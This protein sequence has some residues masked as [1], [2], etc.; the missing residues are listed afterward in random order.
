[1]GAVEAFLAAIR[2]DPARAVVALDYDGTLAPIVERPEDAV[3]EPGAVDALVELAG[4][5]GTLAVITG[6]PA[7][8]VV[9]LG[10][11]DVVPGLVVLGQYGAQRWEAGE[12][13]SDPPSPG[14]AAVRAPLAALVADRA[15]VEDK[16]LSLVVHTRG[17]P[18]AAAVLESL[19]A[20]LTALAASHGLE[21]HPGRLVLEV[22]PPGHD[23]RRAL[24]SLCDPPPS[25]VLCAGDDLGDLPAFAALA[26][27]REAGVPG[28]VVVSAAD[29]APAEIRRSADLLVEGPPGV[30]RLLQ[31]L[32]HERDL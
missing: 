27:L 3:P 30:V 4:H 32:L 18:D 10:G 25:A 22:R 12:L 5:V 7:D 1:M 24:L 19:A 26:H 29:E 2:A 13:V 11:L 9:A 16:G 20:P 17:L 23:K 15:R 31:R 21:V 14:L 8:V 28:L 6:R